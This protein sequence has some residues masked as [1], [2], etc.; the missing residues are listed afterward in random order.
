MIRNP[1]LMI[2]IRNH[3]IKIIF[4][5]LILA[6]LL[7]L[8]LHSQDLRIY[9]DLRMGKHDVGFEIIYITDSSR[10]FKNKKRIF[11]VSVWYPAEYSSE[12]LQLT[13]GD[14]IE[15]IASET[16]P[17]EHSRSKKELAVN[18]YAAHSA[19]FGSN[20]FK[21]KKILL[22]KAYA[23]KM[24]P[25]KSGRFPVIFFVQGRSDSPAANFAMC[26]YLSSNGFVV[27]S[28][29]AIGINK[30]GLDF[31][32]ANLES[33][34][35]DQEFLYRYVTGNFKNIDRQNIFYIGYSY[36]SMTSL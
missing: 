7:P 10:S 18:A 20:I 19:S 14:Y 23:Y 11:Q 5:S 36:G 33:Q 28:I 16:N 6:V 26:E 30:R 21:L 4:L 31:N 12:A 32:E 25:K 24:L 2:I 9:D 17:Y 13:P 35:K 27:V 29:P 3:M 22:D 34:V 1:A 8:S 15:L